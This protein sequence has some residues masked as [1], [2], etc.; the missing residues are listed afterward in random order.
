MVA[1]GVEVRTI[2][3]D[4]VEI[5][6]NVVVEER[7]EDIIDKAL[8]GGRGIGEAE[9]HHCELVMTVAC[10]EGRLWHVFILNTD[11]VVTRAKVEFGEYSCA[12]DTIKDLIDARER[13]PIFDS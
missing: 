2:D 6:Y 5:N 1:M 4:V 8:E 3:Q 13:I 10:A 11:L 7:T 9:G 12:L